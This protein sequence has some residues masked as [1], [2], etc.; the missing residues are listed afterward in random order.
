MKIIKQ[1]EICNNDNLIPVLN[2]G[3][4]PLCDDL[5]KINDSRITKT[6]PIEILFCP[7]CLSAHQKY[8]IPREELFPKEYHYRAKETQDVL[9]GMSNLVNS[10]IESYG[11]L[12]GKKVLDIG[13]NDGSLLNF[14]KN[15]NAL[16]FGVEPTLAALEAKQ[17]HKVINKYFDIN[18]A[19]ELENITFDF[20]TFTNVFAHIDD[21]GQLIE[22]LKIIT[23]EN[24]KIIIENHYLGAVLKNLQFDTFYH[25]HPRTYSLKSFEFIAK[26]LGKNIEKIEFPK[27]YG[28]N[29]RIFI[30]NLEKNIPQN[31]SQ[32]NE[33]QFLNQ[34]S[35]MDKD[36]KIWQ[37]NKSVELLKY[38]EKYGR[39]SAKAFPGRGAILLQMLSLN[40]K[41]INAIYEKPN[42][43][44]I[45]FYAPGTRIPIL[46]DNELFKTNHQIIL[47][48]A[49]HIK[50]EI[51]RYLAQNA[52]IYN[53]KIDKIIDILDE[54]L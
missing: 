20:I 53:I 49:W 38:I 33:S 52:K 54:N 51:R 41:H 12:S 5:V 26:R 19:R 45:G 22:S 16:T 21:L 28:G 14:F 1:C 44:K 40:E 2:L 15:A 8:Q 23:N 3:N 46:S 34:F 50:D 31:P 6:Y 27:R 11:N 7:N 25:E 43:K 36:I 29:I 10:V 35:K 24:T 30:G 37:E 48:I 18:T 13:C 4:H 47:N 32:I 39:L 17:N 9:D 42:S